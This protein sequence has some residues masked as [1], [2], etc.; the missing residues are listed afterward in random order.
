MSQLHSESNAQIAVALLDRHHVRP[1]DHFPVSAGK[2]RI[3][4]SDSSPGQISSNYN[5]TIL[6]GYIQ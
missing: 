6:L 2:K 3:Q 5:A 4:E 1:M